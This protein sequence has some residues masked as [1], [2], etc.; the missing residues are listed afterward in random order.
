MTFAIVSATAVESISSKNFDLIILAVTGESRAWLAA[1]KFRGGDA[2]VWV[3]AR[4]NENLTAIDLEQEISLR[5]PFADVVLAQSFASTLAA[6]L[7]KVEGELNIFIDVSCMTR[8][9]MAVAFDAI[10]ALDRDNI[11]SVSITLSY[12]ISKFTPPEKMSSHNEEIRPISPRFSGWPQDPYASTSIILGLGYEAAKA[13][14]ANE[15]FD[16]QETWVFFPESPVID[17][18]KEVNKNNRQLIDRARREGRLVPYKVDVPSESLFHLLS[19]VQDL[20]TRA[21]PLILPFGPKIFAAISLLIAVVNPSVGIWH[22]TGD[23][24]LPSADH[25]AS[26]YFAA[27][28]VI[29]KRANESE[30]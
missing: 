11:R 3:L 23:T 30:G 25:E 20:A 5:I 13:E 4:K 22:A 19:L 27:V 9:D 14:G 15:Y 2:K 16:A 28:K 21:N 8:A 26:E 12:V 29:I 10:F 1:E 18:D 17:F 7:G 6:Y 24:D